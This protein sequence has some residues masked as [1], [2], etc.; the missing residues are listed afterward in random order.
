M[1]ANEF[2]EAQGL[3]RSA[4]FAAGL[5]LFVLTL[6]VNAIARL[7]V[8]RR[9]AR[10]KRPGAA[11]RAGTAREAC[12][13]TRRP[14]HERARRIE[15]IGWRASPSARRAGAGT[16]SRARAS[17]PPPLIALM[18]LVLIIYYLLRKGLGSWSWSF[19][20]TDPTGNTFFESSEHRRHQERDPRHDR[21]RRARLGDR[22]PDRDRRGGVA[23]RVR[24]APAGSRST[25]RFFVDVLTGVP[26]DHLRP[27]RLHRADRRHR[28]LLRRLQGLDRAV[29]A[30]A[31]G[32][33]PLG[34]GGPA[35]R[36]RRAARIGAGARRAALAGDL[37]HRAADRAAGHGHRRAAGGR[38][39]RRRD[40]AAAVHRG[41]HA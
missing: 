25:V 35:A 17:W 16:G 40:R 10:G 12:W 1:I 30:D 20:T 22:D 9:R 38:P 7:L 3:H 28:Q 15:P 6:L 18:P 11:G 27:V 8:V 19:F 26:V 33:D 24:H 13:P 36:P 41:R 31:P 34:R 14:A 23:R 32:R 4:L 21:D 5:V 29:A 37:Q 39:R 2:G